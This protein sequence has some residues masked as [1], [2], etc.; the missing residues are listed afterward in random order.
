M[1]KLT[2]DQ[3]DY[4]CAIGYSLAKNEELSTGGART[5]FEALPLQARVPALEIFKMERDRTLCCG[6]FK[7]EELLRESQQ[8]LNLIMP[9]D[10]EIV[11]LREKALQAVNPLYYSLL[12]NY[13]QEAEAFRGPSVTDGMEMGY[14]LAFWDK[15]SNPGHSQEVGSSM[16]MKYVL[17]GGAFD[18]FLRSSGNW[19][20][21]GQMLRPTKEQGQAYMR[22]WIDASKQ[23]ESFI[24]ERWPNIGKDPA[25][26]IRQLNRELESIGLADL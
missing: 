8:A 4:A 25:A 5:L 3:F 1:T 12:V 19:S 2:P 26:E 20:Q 21:A 16:A 22:A 6:G 10:S 7:H 13:S 14:C 23:W 24:D 15:F 9:L 11:E 17:S 18:A